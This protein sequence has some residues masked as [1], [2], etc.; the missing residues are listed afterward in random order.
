VLSLA[1]IDCLVYRESPREVRKERR[2]G[3]DDTDD[4]GIRGNYQR[5]IDFH[6]KFQQYGDDSFACL[7][8]CTNLEF[9]NDVIYLQYLLDGGLGRRIKD[10]SR[11]ISVRE[12]LLWMEDLARGVAFIATIGYV[13]GGL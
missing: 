11:P 9:P 6:K 10:T 4:Q 13:H 1:V 7:V 8:R 12:K 2:P 3:Y 5:E